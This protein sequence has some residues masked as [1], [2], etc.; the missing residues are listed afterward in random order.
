MDCKKHIGVTACNTCSSCGEWI[1]DECAIDI[2]GRNFCK[3][4][5]SKRMEVEAPRVGMHGHGHAHG[6]PSKPIVASE[7]KTR[8]RI[9]SFFL[10]LC[11][12]I[13]G[14]GHMY[15]GLIKRGFLIL[16]TFFTACYL[17]SSDLYQSANIFVIIIW[18]TSFFDTFNIKNKLKNGELVH[19]GVDDIKE[20]LQE[21]K[22][23]I[24]A[25]LAIV[26]FAELTAANNMLYHQYAAPI[27]IVFMVFAIVLVVKIF[28]KGSRKEKHD[29]SNKDE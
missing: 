22:R 27:R 5:V 28:F 26:V 23:Y 18:F 2:N 29:D 10:L 19:D 9:N 14:C 25:L 1:C 15:L 11:A 12:I 7:C 24:L 4:C 8:K 13:P 16:T 3:A 21:N 6:A 17:A 20:L